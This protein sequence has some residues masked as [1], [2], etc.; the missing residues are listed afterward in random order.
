LHLFYRFDS[1]IASQD[2][3]S[4]YISTANYGVQFIRSSFSNNSAVQ[5]GGAVFLASSNGDGLFDGVKN[6]VVF[7]NCILSN[8]SAVYGGALYS[9]FEN[10]IIFSSVQFRKNSASLSGNKNIYRFYKMIKF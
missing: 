5:E 8:N 10:V 3:G 7:D 4:V 6:Y 9:F 2:A 1:N